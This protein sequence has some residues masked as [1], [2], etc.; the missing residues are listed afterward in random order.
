MNISKRI[1]FISNCCRP[2][3]APKII[4]I[5]VYLIIKYISV[6]SFKQNNK[7]FFVS[8][9]NFKEKDLRKKE[10]TNSTFD[11][12]NVVHLSSIL[13]VAMSTSVVKLFNTQ[14]KLY[15]TLGLYIHRS[16]LWHSTGLATAKSLFFLISAV[17]FFI[18]TT[19]FFLFEAQT[20]NEYGM[21]FYISITILAVAIN[22]TTIAWQI[23]QISRLMRNYEEFIDKSQFG[24]FLCW[25]IFKLLESFYINFNINLL[26]Q[27]EYFDIGSRICASS[28]SI[29]IEL[30]K[31]IELVCNVLRFM[32][33][34]FTYIFGII[35][36]QILITCVNYF[37]YDLKE[38][39]FYLTCPMMCVQL[40]CVIYL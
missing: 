17:Q 27:W 38:E 13:T 4:I 18:T 24:V 40:N 7:K 9:L 15:K 2:D 20:I 26:F 1:D 23:D 11:T 37:V 8:V 30:N 22:T 3:F 32:L 14:R 10:Q 16:Q 35:V 21:S 6:I 28:T 34:K 12:T 19:A 31:K 29:Y 33:M 36:P 39:S 25:N 5:D